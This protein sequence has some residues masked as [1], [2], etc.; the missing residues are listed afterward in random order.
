LVDRLTIA[1]ALRDT[2]VELRNAG[3]AQAALD[4][5][6][7][8]GHVLQWDVATL[9]ARDDEPLGDGARQHLF[10]L[11]RRAVSG[12]PMAYILGEKA[13]LEHILHVGSEVLIPRPE[14]EEVV[15]EISAPDASVRQVLDLGTGSGALLIALLEA[16][17]QAR[18]WGVDAS[19][20]ALGYARTNLA[21]RPQCPV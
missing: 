15:A 4:A 17:P 13:F 6:L 20:T 14:S 19:E 1:T 12:E 11:T 21:R 9:R 10:D 18:G 2:T 5:R 8:L 7:L 3:R 16:F